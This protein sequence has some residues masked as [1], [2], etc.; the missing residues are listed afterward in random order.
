MFDEAA[1]KQHPPR[2]PT[3]TIVRQMTSKTTAFFS[4]YFLLECFAC[5]GTE[6]PTSHIRMQ[7]TLRNKAH[8]IRLT[9]LPRD[10]AMLLRA[11][12]TGTPHTAG[13]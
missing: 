8:K 3:A 10:N 12:S 9:P 4:S 7:E 13:P 11:S 6:I 5:R 2:P 1:E